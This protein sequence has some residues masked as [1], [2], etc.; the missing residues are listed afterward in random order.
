MNEERVRQIAQQVHDSNST[1]DQFAVGQ[2]PFHTH[3][4]IDSPALTFTT[5]TFAGVIQDSGF[6]D[7]TVVSPFAGGETSATLSS[8]WQFS[9]GIY[10]TQFSNG[11]VNAVTY[12]AGS[13]VISWST[14]LSGTATIHLVVLGVGATATF[15]PKGW[16]LLQAGIGIYTIT[17]NLNTE[18]YSAV[19]TSSDAST[20]TYAS[21]TPSKDSVT[22]IFTDSDTGVNASTSFGFQL[23]AVTNKAPAFPQ[24]QLN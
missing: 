2:V 10:M 7:T 17:H 6:F 22:F 3:N 18:F 21:T 15:L 16:V 20:L 5:I 13:V 4:D 11:D 23:T 9:S 19:A 24:Y 8:K 12:T 14:G 1:S